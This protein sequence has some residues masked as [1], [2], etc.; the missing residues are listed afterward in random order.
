MHN[1][2]ERYHK[3]FTIGMGIAIAVHLFVI[4]LL[5]FLLKNSDSNEPEYYFNSY[6]VQLTD[7]H[8]KDTNWGGGGSFGNNFDD[9]GKEISSPKTLPGIPVP[10]PEPGEFEFG[11]TTNLEESKDSLTGSGMGSGTGTGI[12]SGSGTGAGEG[13]GWGFGYKALPFVPRQILEVVPQNPEG[14]KGTIRL[15]LKI[16]TDGFVKED[17]IIYNTTNNAACLMNTIEAAYKSRWE[18]ISIEG[19]RIEYWVE[20]TYKFN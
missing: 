19:K 4:L 18:K 5:F 10:A 20:K 8:S 15:V 14:V 1:W 16:G 2:R 17:K 9:V 13:S 7:F 3:N 11:T 12:G 6:T